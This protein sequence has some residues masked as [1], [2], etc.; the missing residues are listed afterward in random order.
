MEVDGPKCNVV[1]RFYRMID[2]LWEVVA[3]SMEYSRPVLGRM[4]R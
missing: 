3:S 2:R 4:R 1:L